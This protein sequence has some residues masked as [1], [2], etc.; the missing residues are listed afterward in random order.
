MS[1]QAYTVIAVW[2]IRRNFYET[3]HRD[4]CCGGTAGAV[5]GRHLQR[6]SEEEKRCGGGVLHHGC[7]PEKAVGSDPEFGEYCKGLRRS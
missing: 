1:L 7:V 5:A 2:H 4:S 6:L 3:C